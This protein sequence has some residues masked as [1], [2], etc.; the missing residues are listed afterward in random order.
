MRVWQNEQHSWAKSL[1]QPSQSQP[2]PGL[3]LTDSPCTLEQLPHLHY[4]H[5]VA[6]LDV[7]GVH[8]HLILASEAGGVDSRQH[9]LVL[10]ARIDVVVLQLHEG[11]VAGRS[12][13][14]DGDG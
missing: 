9:E 10:I 7:E 12:I 2:N 4:E 5:H 6:L 14:V 8:A 11:A 13:S 3:R 1:D